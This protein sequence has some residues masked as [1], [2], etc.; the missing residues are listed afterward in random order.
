[1]SGAEVTST[2]TLK[3]KLTLDDINGG[4]NV[5][6]TPNAKLALGGTYQFLENITLVVI[7]SSN[8]KV[9]KTL[10]LDNSGIWTYELD[11]S[12]I[13]AGEVTVTLKGHGVDDVE[14]T[15]I[16]DNQAPTL[17]A[18]NDVSYQLEDDALTVTASFSKPVTKPTVSVSSGLQLT[19]KTDGDPLKKEWVS[20]PLSLASVN[21]N[22]ESL[23][24]TFTG[25]QDKAGNPGAEVKSTS[26]LMPKLTLNKIDGVITQGATLDLSGTYQALATINLVVTDI[27]GVKVDKTLDLD[28]SGTWTYE[29]DLS[30]IAVGEVKVTVRGHGV[31][32]VK[33]S[34]TY[35]NQAPTLDASKDVS[36][37]LED[38]ALT[39][40]ASFS[41]PVTK[42]TVSVSSGLQLTWKTDGDPLKKEWVS[43]PLSLASHKNVESLAFTFTG[44]KDKAGNSGAKVT[45]TYTLKPELTLNK[46]DGVIT[47]GATLPLS[48]TYQAL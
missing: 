31:D 30:S 12:S 29:L 24:F 11:L 39:L 2:Y 5:G 15:F 13:A 28:N 36:Y 18:P 21:K 37:Q 42:P 46:I 4:K 7:D 38:D 6:I 45:K 10:N 44:F 1:N 32:D 47:Q 25:F 27:T 3:P 33:S 48:G 23:A 19:W 40:T 22:V 41:E 17:D 8:A 26:T 9:E 34:F 14:S 20:E 16:Y 35:D 43:E